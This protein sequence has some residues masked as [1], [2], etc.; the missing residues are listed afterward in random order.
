MKT[1]ISLFAIITLV[2][3]SASKLTGPSQADIDRISE[4]F[5]DYT[6]AQLND[7]KML[8]EKNCDLCHG[9]KSPKDKD[10]DGWRKIVPVM[11]EKVHKKG[12]ELNSDQE[13]LI[14]KYLITMSG[15]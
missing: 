6:L 11:V 3:C 9:M 10:E 8:Y 2:A 14:L 15:K 1:L 5:P 7:G 12:K 4:K 13:E